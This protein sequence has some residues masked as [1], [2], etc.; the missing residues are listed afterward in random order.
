[1]QIP[2][3]PFE[4]RP[5]QFE[6]IYEEAG[7]LIFRQA[8]PIYIVE[9]LRLLAASVFAIFDLKALEMANQNLRLDD[10]F[11]DYVKRFQRLQFIGEDVALALL[12]Q[13]YV[14]NPGFTLMTAFLSDLLKRAFSDRTVTYISGKSALRR[15]AGSGRRSSY[16]TW[17]R[18]A[19][20]VETA[21]F[22]HV[23]NC[24]VPLSSVGVDR[25]S[26]QIVPGSHRLLRQRPVDYAAP[27]NP[28][29]DEVDD[30]YGHENICTALLEAGDVLLFGHHTLHRTQP[31]N[32]AHPDR[33]SGEFR[34][35]IK[36]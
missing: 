26:L 6:R 28:D 23:V 24:W 29:E 5:Y 27:D 14:A 30:V 2:E 8:L 9:H 10:P 7:T 13:S 12:A 36:H 11:V 1:M 32:S 34:F 17:H 4:F 16:V 20:A 3:L 19:H 21:E 25:P 22:P 18:D 33:V 31:M 35:A 15:Q